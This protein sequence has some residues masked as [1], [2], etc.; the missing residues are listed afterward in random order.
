MRTNPTV[1]QSSLALNDTQAA[2][3]VTGINSTW[4]APASMMI[5]FNVSGATT[6]RPFIMTY[7][8][9]GG[10]IAVSAEL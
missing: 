7:A 3:T 8:S 5:E 9:T 2:F 4:I 1:T 10:F 6:Y